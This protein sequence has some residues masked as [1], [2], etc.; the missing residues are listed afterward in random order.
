ML[1]LNVD[2]HRVSI[3]GERRS[4]QRRLPAETQFI[5]DEHHANLWV[6]QG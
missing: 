3:S 4:S 1:I 6:F 5:C 2:F